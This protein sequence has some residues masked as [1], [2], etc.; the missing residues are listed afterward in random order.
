MYTYDLLFHLFFTVDPIPHGP[1]STRLNKI[2][3]PRNIIFLSEGNFSPIWRNNLGN[4]LLES[5]VDHP[6]LF[7]VITDIITLNIISHMVVPFILSLPYQTAKFQARERKRGQKS[8][9]V[10]STRGKQNRILPQIYSDIHFLPSTR[11][12]NHGLN[13]SKRS[14]IW[15][16]C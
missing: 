5:M 3:I 14:T 13:T 12:A 6:V 11:V 1:Q 15:K 16:Q 9:V 10:S 4:I 8:S 7:A 2:H